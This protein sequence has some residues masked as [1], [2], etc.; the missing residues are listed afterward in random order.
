LIAW[1]DA[2]KVREEPYSCR[3]KREQYEERTWLGCR[4]RTI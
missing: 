3:M 4:W 1:N 2:K